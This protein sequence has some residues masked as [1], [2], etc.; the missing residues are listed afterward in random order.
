MRYSPIAQTVLR[1]V[2]HLVAGLLLAGLSPPLPL[3]V[4]PPH[5]KAQPDGWAFNI[6][7]PEQDFLRFTQDRLTTGLRPSS[8]P[9]GGGYSP[10]LPLPVSPPHEKAQP[11]GW[12]FNV[13]LPEQDS[14]LRQSG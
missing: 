8:R 13:W 5:E 10:P 7:L 9:G 4:S 6:W 3:S 11:A 2:N 1:Q 14:N 12:A